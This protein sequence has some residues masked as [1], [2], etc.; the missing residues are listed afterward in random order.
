M[1]INKLPAEMARTVPAMATENHL[2][3][4]GRPRRLLREISKLKCRVLGIL[5]D[6]RRDDLTKRPSKM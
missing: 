2:S 4:A 3:M 6:H 5:G 1:Q